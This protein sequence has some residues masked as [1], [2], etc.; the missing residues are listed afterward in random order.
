MADKQIGTLP[1]A[2]SVSDDALLV[3][4]IQGVAVRIT[5]KQLKD[6]VAHGVDVYVASA[7][8]A[9]TD[10]ADAAKTAQDAANSIGTAVQDTAA[11]AQAAQD[12]RDAI[13]NMIVEAVT[14]ATGKPATVSKSL[15]DGVYKLVFGLPAG[16]K[17]D[18][19]NPGSS[20]R[21]IDRT[22]GT[23]AAGTVDTYT[24]TLTD[25]TVGGTFAVYNGMDGIGSGD[26]LASVY[27]PQRKAQDI[28][29]YADDAAKHIKAEN[30][31]FADGET[32]QAKYDAGELTGPAGRDGAAGPAGKDGATGPTGAAGKDA[33]IN[34]VNALTLN[35]TGGISGTQNGSTYTLDGSSLK[36]QKQLITLTAAGWMSAAAPGVPVVPGVVVG[37]QQT[38][39]V[40]GISA[41]EGA[42]W[43]RPV[44]TV[45]SQQAYLAAGI[46]C[47]GFAANSL[48]FTADTV[49]TVN[50]S[51]YILIS[52]VGA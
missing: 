31:T 19:G 18:K 36:P 35:A 17:G 6:L 42:Q 37:N 40:P 2:P 38:V 43:V 33:T 47:T 52:E 21:S 32:F 28:F 51:V 44:P 16:A 13:A 50:L 8:K 26:M 14:L 46:R 34:G 25:G 45:A 27:D 10:A 5:G 23:G 41:D 9:A 49:P 15:V 22:S 48:T 24:I 11:N 30:V 39:S 20:I 3:A 1:A 7:Q 12:A 29:K 4:E